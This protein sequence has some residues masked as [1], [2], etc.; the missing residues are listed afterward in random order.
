MNV[1]VVGASGG[2]GSA[3]ARALIGRGHQVW[4]TARDL[5]AL[6]PGLAGAVALDLRRPDGPETLAR[7]LPDAPFGLVVVASGIHARSPGVPVDAAHRLEDLRAD[8]LLD[9]VQV[10]A[11]APIL[12]VRALAPRLVGGTVLLLTS[13]RGSLSAK[14]DGGN[15]GY[16]A[17]KAT[18]NMLGRAMAYDLAPQSTRVLLV[19][20]GVVRTPMGGPDASLDADESAR[21]LLDLAERADDSYAGRLWWWDGEEH[22]W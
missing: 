18:L 12:I 5:S 22:A 7:A 17:S 21:A 9:M 1:L 4:G 16:C 14:V 11:I 13:R 3:L 20:P 15:Y 10:N 19:H 6:P 8:V 2:I